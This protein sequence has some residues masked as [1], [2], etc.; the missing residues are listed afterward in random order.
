MQ[1]LAYVII[2]LGVLSGAV[3]VWSVVAS[4]ARGSLASLSL[5]QALWIFK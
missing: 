2:V 4:V 3:G 1:V 5:G